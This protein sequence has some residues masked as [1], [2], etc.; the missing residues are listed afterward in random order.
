MQIINY[1]DF[2]LIFKEVKKNQLE[3]YPTAKDY[4][5]FLKRIEE[6]YHYVEEMYKSFNNLPEDYEF[7]NSDNAFD[8]EVIDLENNLLHL[9][10]SIGGNDANENGDDFWGY[11]WQYTI[12]LEEELFVSY[13]FENYS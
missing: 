7:T 3:E 12:D 13:F 4:I 2:E 1:I 9:E 5:K 10:L 6:P 8:V 11:G